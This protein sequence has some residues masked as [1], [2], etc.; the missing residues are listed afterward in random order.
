[1]KKYSHFFFTVG[2]VKQFCRNYSIDGKAIVTLI[3]IPSKNGEPKVGI[4]VRNGVGKF[5]WTADLSFSTQN[6]PQKIVKTEPVATP[7]VIPSK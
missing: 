5:A 7:Y 2:D 6:F 1:M 4:I 3:D